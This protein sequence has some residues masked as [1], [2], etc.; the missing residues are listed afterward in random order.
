MIIRTIQDKSTFTKFLL[1]IKFH[2]ELS[3]MI[4]WASIV[5]KSYVRRLY[6]NGF[7]PNIVYISKYKNVIHI[8]WIYLIYL[9]FYNFLSKVFYLSLNSYLDNQIF[10]TDL[11]KC[12][13]NRLTRTV[14]VIFCRFSILFND[15]A[16]EKIHT[17]EQ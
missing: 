2:K 3:I 7:H 14:K 16:L 10:L 12:F 15:W 9:K 1:H 13:Y 4:L 6:T 8:T 11:H 17:R 5:L